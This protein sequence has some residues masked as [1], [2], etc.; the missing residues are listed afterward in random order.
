MISPQTWAGVCFQEQLRVSKEQL[1]KKQSVKNSKGGKKMSI[2]FSGKDT[3]GLQ[4]ARRSAMQ[5][6]QNTGRQEH[7]KGLPKKYPA[8]QK[9]MKRVEITSKTKILRAHLADAFPQNTFSVRVDCKSNPTCITVIHDA[10]KE[11]VE[12]ITALYADSNSEIVLEHSTEM[13]R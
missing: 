4:R 2:P 7:I 1:H 11:N 13:S 9:Q 12:C 10:V 8:K 6:L 5:H 3:F